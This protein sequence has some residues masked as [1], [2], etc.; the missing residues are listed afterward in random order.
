MNGRTGLGELKDEENG[1]RSRREDWKT[2]K[3]ETNRKKVGEG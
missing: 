3:K 1:W 2:G